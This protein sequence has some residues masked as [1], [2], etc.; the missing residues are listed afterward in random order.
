MSSAPFTR[1]ITSN[2]SSAPDPACQPGCR[3][4]KRP[5]SKSG[6]TVVLQRCR[7]SAAMSQPAPASSLQPSARGWGWLH[8]LRSM[9]WVPQPA[10]QQQKPGLLKRLFTTL[11]STAAASSVQQA[12]GAGPSHLVVMVN[13][14]FGGPGARHSWA[15]RRA[16]CMAVVSTWH[17]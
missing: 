14:L 15:A 16:S 12:G 5:S 4:I 11:Q 8:P 9:G 17:G 10:Q 13:G 3:S 1:R 7:V 2:C 6:R